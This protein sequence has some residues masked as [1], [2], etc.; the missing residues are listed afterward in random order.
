MNFFSTSDVRSDGRFKPYRGWVRFSTPQF[1]IR[2]GLQ[3]INFGSA[4]LLRPLMWFDRIDPRDPLHL[5]DGVYALLLRYYFLNNANIWT[6]LL[7]GNEDTRGWDV[8]ASD[9]NTPEFGGRIQL[10]VLSGETGLTF[11]QRRMDLFPADT[12]VTERRVGLDG[13]W[14]LGIGLWFEG[15][16]FN[17]ESPAL[18]Y[19]WRYIFS[20][21]LDYTFNVGRGL[22]VLAEHFFTENSEKAFG[23]GEGLAFSSLSFNYPLGLLD[24]VSGIV[25]YDWE[26]SQL[27][28]FINW[29]R[30]YDRWR[31][32]VMGFWNPQD[33]QIYQS[34]EQKHLFTG[35]GFQVMVSYHF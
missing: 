4:S 17:Q 20:A 23:A 6:W 33:F 26:N 16:L 28:R 7:Y 34:Q 21:G 13:K 19:P 15:V 27:Y 11:H 29:Q 18:A 10:P 5:T 30:T 9:A 3:K 24:S 31:V 2:L 35:T 8:F 22:Y 25:Y 12:A 14:D 32:Y 1:E